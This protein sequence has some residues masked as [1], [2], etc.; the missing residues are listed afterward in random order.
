MPRLFFALWPDD[1]VR[2]QCRQYQQQLNADHYR[3]V[4]PANFHITLSFLGQ[5][6]DAETESLLALNFSG[7]AAPFQLSIDSCGY[8]RRPKVVWMAPTQIPVA[9]PNLVDSINLRVAALELSMDKRPYQPH[10]TLARKAKSAPKIPPPEPILWNI[11]NFSLVQSSSSAEGQVYQ[12]LK[13]W[14]LS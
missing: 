13:N 1:N 5:V 7:T 9:L 2:S 11:N 4:K 10:L 12:V 14:P 6:S 8:W 3:L